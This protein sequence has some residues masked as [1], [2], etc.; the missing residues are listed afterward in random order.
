MTLQI[1]MP[2]YNEERHIAET[3]DS[4]CRQTFRDWRLTIHDNASTDRTVAIC[5]AIARKDGRVKVDAGRRN[6]GAVMQ[7]LRAHCHYDADYVSFRSANDVLRQDYYAATMDLIQSDPSI[8]LAYSHGWDCSH[9]AHWQQVPAPDEY[10]IDTRGM[11]MMSGCAEVM[12][13]YTAPFSLWGVYRRETLELCR[14]GQYGYGSDH[15]LV[16]EMAL[17]GAVAPTAER[18]DIRRRAAATDTE[19]AKGN[20]LALL[21][22][23]ARGIP[24]SSVF[25]GVRHFFPFTD[26]AHAH[27][28]MIRLAHIP[29]ESKPLLM[30][31]AV[32][33]FRVRFGDMIRD[34]A[35]RLATLLEYLGERW[36]TVGDDDRL[37]TRPMLAHVTTEAHKARTLRIADVERLYEIDTLLGSLR[38][39]LC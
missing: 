2:A 3:L 36:A 8:G 38:T 25:Y 19:V 11:S 21:E 37:H 6:V 14:H 18:L 24:S 7:A 20:S 15:V 27:L 16:A 30:R 4:I 28:E 10:R 12:G 32:D 31:C 13:R 33:T 5:N 39:L 23:H 34:E 22:E 9:D 1:H 26:M 17:Y 29:C 35:D